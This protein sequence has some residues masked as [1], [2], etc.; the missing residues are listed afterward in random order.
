MDELMSDRVKYLLLGLGGVVAIGGALA[1]GGGEAPSQQPT[2]IVT[3]KAPTLPAAPQPDPEPSTVAEADPAAA[4]PAAAPGAASP[5]A[6][7]N[8]VS[9]E[10][11]PQEDDWGN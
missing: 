4:P 9:E 3:T 5:A 1:L 10:A 11:A 2:V 8:A 7:P 6:D